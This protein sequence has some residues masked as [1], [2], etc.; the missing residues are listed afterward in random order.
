MDKQDAIQAGKRMAFVALDAGAEMGTVELTIEAYRENLSDTLND[1]GNA[2]WVG[3]ARDAFDA[4]IA[5][6]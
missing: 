5:A 6:A 1:E 3:I 4:A 2:E